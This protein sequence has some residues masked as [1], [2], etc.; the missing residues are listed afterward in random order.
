MANRLT[1]TDASSGLRCSFC[2]RAPEEGVLVTAPEVAICADLRG[3]AAPTCS[4]PTTATKRTTRLPPT[5]QAP[6]PCVRRLLGEADVAG[7]LSVDDTLE[8]MKTALPRFSAGEVV[9]PV[10]T[11]RRG[12][13]PRLSRGHAGADP[14][15]PALGAKLVS[16]FPGNADLGL[17]THTATVVLLIPRTGRLTSVMDGRLIT[18]LR[19]AAVSA[20]SPPCSRARRPRCSPSS[21]RAS[22]RAVTSR[23]SSACGRSARCACGARRP[24]TAPTSWRPWGPG[25]RRRCWRLV[26]RKTRCAAPTSCVLA[27]SSTEPV[28]ESAW[29]AD[30]AHVISVGACRP[31][32]REMDPA[33]VA[34]AASTW[35]RARPPRP[36]RATSSSASPNT[37]SRPLTSSE[38][39]A[40]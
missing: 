1:R 13:R 10:R 40:T 14:R 28:V 19:T 39:S 27:T 6:R 16:V 31:D 36:S 37:G 5:T 25:R 30:G 23:R 21:E 22:R 2:G 15:P 26:R 7:L 32:Q 24:S 9:Q 12:R 3:A 11:R 33:L 35:T 4:K 18:E 17:P 34:R 29:I 8:A 38:S 20:L